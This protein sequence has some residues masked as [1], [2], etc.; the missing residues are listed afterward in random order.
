[1]LTVNLALW[2]ITA[3]YGL[4]MFWGL[5]VWRITR[6]RPRRFG[7]DKPDEEANQV[8]SSIADQ[9][10]KHPDLAPHQMTSPAS[11]EIAELERLWTLPEH[12][13]SPR[14]G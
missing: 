2:L 4:M 1:V 3:A 13:A 5:L 9:L 8:C 11:T 10:D 14:S 12:P 7:E 6:A